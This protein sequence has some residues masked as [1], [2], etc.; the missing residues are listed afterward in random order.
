MRSPLAVFLH[1]T[2]ERITDA[3]KAR[4]MPEP[5]NKGG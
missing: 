2:H 3:L 1:H 5:D 4:A